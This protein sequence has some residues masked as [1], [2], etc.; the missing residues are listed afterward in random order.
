MG[1][2]AAAARLMLLEAQRRPFTGSV[3][4][5]GRSSVYVTRAELE[6]W[7]RRH[8]VALSG[9][10]SGH[11]HDPR[12]ARQGCLDDEGFFR[13]LGFERVEALDIAEWE[14]AAV[15]HD[16]NRPVPAELHARWDVIFETGTTVQIFDTATVLA[17]LARMVAVGGRII[18]A[19]VPSHNHVD[20]GFA[21]PSPTLYADF[22]AANGF[23]L[24]SCYLCLLET[25]WHRGRLFTPSCDVR[26]YQPGAIDHL[27]YGRFGSRQLALFVVAE[28]TPDST[29]D[30]IPQL[31]QYRQ[32]WQEFDTARSHDEEAVAGLQ[33]R[34]KSRGA[35]ASFERILDASPLLD[36]LWRPVK[37]VKEQLVRRLP[38]RWPPRVVRF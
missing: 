16:L 17:N 29:S 34:W 38:R 7:A 13:L 11:S 35:A 12:L 24:V 14:Q 30:Q 5:L 9:A 25:Y 22:Y 6:G 4:Q 27:S 28:R 36:R 32:S 31:G 23:R 37:R 33:Q 21:M 1:I 3:L 19:L 15:I 2:P 20:L 8:R 10:A 26:R 18:H